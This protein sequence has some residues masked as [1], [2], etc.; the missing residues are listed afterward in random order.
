MRTR[1]DAEKKPERKQTIKKNAKAGFRQ[2]DLLVEDGTTKR[3][4]IFIGSLFVTG[5]FLKTE[6]ARAEKAEISVP[7]KEEKE[8]STVKSL[9]SNPLFGAA[10]VIV[11]AGMYVK[12]KVLKNYDSSKEKSSFA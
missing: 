4:V 2:K 5:M 9:A 12:Y 1:H 10:M 7:P 8:Y 11:A 3:D 6:N